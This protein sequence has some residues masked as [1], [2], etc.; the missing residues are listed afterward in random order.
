MRHRGIAMAVGAHAQQRAIGW[1]DPIHAGPP[2]MPV[3]ARIDPPSA[4]PGPLGTLLSTLW[5]AF[6]TRPGSSAVE[7]EVAVRL[8]HVGLVAL[9]EVLGN[10]HVP[11]YVARCVTYVLRH[12]RHHMCNAQH[13]RGGPT[14]RF[15]RTACIPAS[16]QIACTCVCTHARVSAHT[17]RARTRRSPSVVSHAETAAVRAGGSSRL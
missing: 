6:Q 16:R 7:L 15:F 10:D 11:A 1:C 4:C 8:L 9:L 14:H 2:R 17:H 3:R 5:Q 12:R 13:A